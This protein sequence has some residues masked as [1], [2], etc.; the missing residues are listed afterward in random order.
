MLSWNSSCK[1][2]ATLRTS[3]R[4]ASTRRQGNGLTEEESSG[5]TILDDILF[6][7]GAL[8]AQDALGL[9]LAHDGDDLL[10]GP[11][12]FL[13]LDGTEGLHVFLEHVG[14]AL[15]HAA[16]DLVF[17]LLAGAFQRDRQHLAIDLGQHFLQ[18][19]GIDEQ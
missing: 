15:R 11:I 5:W 6:A 14:S 4:S 10:L 7:Y 9:K 18:A 13:D 8:E 17:Q 16:Q 12:H 3:S 1:S 2:P 19:Q